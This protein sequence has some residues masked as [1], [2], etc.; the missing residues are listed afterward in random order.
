MISGSFAE[1]DVQVQAFCASLSPCSGCRVCDIHLP[2]FLMLLAAR[3]C[4]W[5]HIGT[6]Q[7]GTQRFVTNMSLVAVAFLTCIFQ[8]S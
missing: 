1:R 5:C 3:R 7:G 4:G 6:I 8:F 2:I